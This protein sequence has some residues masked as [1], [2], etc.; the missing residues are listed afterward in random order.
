M[1]PYIWD[2]NY[3]VLFLLSLL[4]GYL[5]SFLLICS[6]CFIKIRFCAHSGSGTKLSRCEIHDFIWIGHFFPF[7][8]GVSI[9]LLILPIKF[10]LILLLIVH[11][12]LE[13]SRVGWR[14]ELPTAHL[15]LISSQLILVIYLWLDWFILQVDMRL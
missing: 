7:S 4:L 1:L 12:V 13:V 10:L 9:V 15:V 3:L 11:V 2:Y 5:L 14:L 8:K 6:S